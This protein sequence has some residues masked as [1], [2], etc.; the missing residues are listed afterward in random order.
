MVAIAVALAA[1]TH[2]AAQTPDGQSLFATH[3]QKCHGPNGKPS[4]GMK[5]LLP[6]LP[7]WDAAFFAKRTEEDILAVLKNGKGR[8][9]KPWGDKLT[10]D[11][12]VAVARYI[13]TLRP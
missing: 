13:R 11:E 9:M 3:C 12:M 5:K 7:T 6:E 1:G 4:A 8:N 10:P 2:A